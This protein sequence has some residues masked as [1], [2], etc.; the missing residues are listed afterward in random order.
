MVQRY[1]FES[2]SQQ[3]VQF[4]CKSWCCFQWFKGTNLKANHNESQQL[5]FDSDAVSNGSKVQIWKQITTDMGKQKHELELFPMVQRYKFESKSQQLWKHVFISACCFQWFKGTNLKANHNQ[6]EL[7]DVLDTAVSN[8]SKVQIWKQITTIGESL[9]TQ[10]T[11]FPM[12]QRYKFESKSQQLLLKIKFVQGCFQWFKGTN[13]KAN[14]NRQRKK[15]HYST[16]VSNGSKVQIWKQITT[17]ACLE[18]RNLQLFPMVQRYKFES[19]SQ[20]Q[21]GCCELCD[22]CFQWFKGTN[23]KANHNAYW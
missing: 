20:R 11:L 9:I 14:H 21:Y 17:N 6:R 22:S 3:Q 1:K 10:A 23:L 7:K 18:I 5:F 12:V 8:G 16:A 4:Y 19:K 15:P 2:K 13:L